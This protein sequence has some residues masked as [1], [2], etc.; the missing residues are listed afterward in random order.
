MYRVLCR[1]LDENIFVQ[2]RIQCLLISIN[3][4]QYNTYNGPSDL[5]LKV[6]SKEIELIEVDQR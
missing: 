5:P 6:W 1:I 3:K 2:G 4:Q